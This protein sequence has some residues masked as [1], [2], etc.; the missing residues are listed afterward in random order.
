M[1]QKHD[2]YRIHTAGKA[3]NASGEYHVPLG[4]ELAVVLLPRTLGDRYVV[5][6]STCVTHNVQLRR[7]MFMTMTCCTAGPHC[8][9]NCTTLRPHKNTAISYHTNTFQWICLSGAQLSHLYT[10]VLVKDRYLYSIFC[11]IP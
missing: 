10:G 4:I 2:T 5:Q 6:R 8:I 9:N 1:A 3:D 7:V 11:Q